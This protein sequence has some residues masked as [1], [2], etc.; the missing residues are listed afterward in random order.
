MWPGRT[1]AIVGGGAGIVGEMGSREQLNF[2]W[3][4]LLVAASFSLPTSA[5]N[6]DGKKFALS[7]L[8]YVPYPDDGI[9]SFLLRTNCLEVTYLTRDRR[10][11][12]RTGEGFS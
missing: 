5:S 7:F 4:V 11:T 12:E 10:K 6:Q 2:G 8:P 9:I 3:L 1:T